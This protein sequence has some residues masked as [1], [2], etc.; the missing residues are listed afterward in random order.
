MNDKNDIRDIPTEQGK[1]LYDILWNQKFIIG[2]LNALEKKVSGMETAGYGLTCED[3]LTLEVVK[4]FVEDFD[5][6]DYVKTCDFDPDNYDFDDFVCEGDAI[7][8][9][10]LEEHVSD[11]VSESMYY[12]VTDDQLDDRLHDMATEEYV[13][14]V[15]SD[16]EDSL[17]ADRI[18]DTL[19]ERLDKEVGSETITPKTAAFG[20]LLSVVTGLS[21]MQIARQAASLIEDVSTDDST[22]GDAC[23]TIDS[24]CGAPTPQTH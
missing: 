8:R 17:T 1:I 20:A 6:D 7:T 14:G 21:T 22:S 18:M 10:D 24:T 16:L 19:V 9:A 4:E 11:A 5:S 3:R 13:D 12:Y 2:R 23:D 15:K